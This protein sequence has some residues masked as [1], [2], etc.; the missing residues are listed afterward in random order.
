MCHSQLATGGI[1]GS[2]RMAPIRKDVSV[3]TRG[4]PARL[5]RVMSAL[6]Q[7]HLCGR[8]WTGSYC[9][10]VSKRHCARQS[11]Y[12]CVRDREESQRLRNVSL[13]WPF[14]KTVSMS[15]ADDVLLSQSTAA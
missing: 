7:S 2:I 9:R 3:S 11:Q 13:P 5:T 12:T 15:T 4:Y 10:K 14:P 6:L 8:S 1:H